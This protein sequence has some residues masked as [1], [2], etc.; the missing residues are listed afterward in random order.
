M[1]VVII[2]GFGM[3]AQTCGRDVS[4][5]LLISDLLRASGLPPKAAHERNRHALAR[6]EA[7]NSAETQQQQLWTL[8]VDNLPAVEPAVETGAWDTLLAAEQPVITSSYD[9][10][11][12]TAMY[13]KVFK[14]P[15]AEPA[16][17]HQVILTWQSPLPVLRE[18]FT[19]G[20]AMSRT[21]I[22]YREGSVLTGD[23]LLGSRFGQARNVLRK[24]DSL[25]ADHVF[26]LV[27]IE[28]GL[29]SSLV[30]AKVR[31]KGPV[32]RVVRQGVKGTEG[33]TDLYC[34]Y[35]PAEA[36]QESLRQSLLRV[37]ESAQ[38]VF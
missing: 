26:F 21:K 34:E 17:L 11:A 33:V 1:S 2:A 36:F 7:H 4:L 30:K 6:W 25:F 24:I 8:L 20:S 38:P 13:R 31:R 18:F 28:H 10:H 14:Q 9:L 19:P 22:L 15:P 37:L 27:G 32:F 5:R 16:V 12:A 35:A 29:D 23:W 3:S